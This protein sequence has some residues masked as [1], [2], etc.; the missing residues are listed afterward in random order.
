MHHGIHP[1]SL[2]LLLNIYICVYIYIYIYKSL[3]NCI[4][5]L[6]YCLTSITEAAN[7]MQGPP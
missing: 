3:Q 7:H 6:F 2:C 1:S 5:F 4:Y